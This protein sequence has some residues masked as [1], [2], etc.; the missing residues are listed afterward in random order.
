MKNEARQGALCVRNGMTEQERKYNSSVICRKIK[1]LDEFKKAKTI[2][3]YYPTNSEVDITQ[4]FN[5]CKDMDKRICLP[6]VLDGD[7]QMDVALYDENSSLL[8]D[9][10]GILYPHDAEKVKKSD[11]DFVIVPMVAFD[12][13]LNRIGYGRGY[14]DRFLAGTHAYKLGV[15]F[16]CQQVSEIIKDINDIKMDKIIT[17]K[18]IFY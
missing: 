17:E 1:G 4:I 15:A 13:N 12:G 8:A 10:F 9:R 2:M 14:Y 5:V 11:I 16:S 7:G 18:N 3:A 6:V